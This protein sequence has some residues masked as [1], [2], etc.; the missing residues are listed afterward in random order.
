MWSP[1]PLS[2]PITLAI[3]GGCGICRADA[4]VVIEDT[5]GSASDFLATR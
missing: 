4:V 2:L 5:S 3:T 1:W